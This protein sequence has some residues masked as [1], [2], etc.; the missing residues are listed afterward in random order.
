M[1]STTLQRL[2]LFLALFVGLLAP[3]VALPQTPDP[4]SVQPAQ[5]RRVYLPLVQRAPLGNSIRFAVIGDYG[6]DNQPEADVAKL[7]KS[8]NPYFIVT[9]GDNNYP[10]GAAATI[11][12]NVGK[13]YYQ[14]ISPYS[15]QYGSNSG[16]N[17]F[18][19]VMGNHD[20][21][22][23]NGKPYLNYFTLPNNERYYE[24]ALGP[25]RVFGLDSDEREP[26]GVTATSKQ[27]R[28]LQRRLAASRTCW[29]VVVS[30]HSPF[31]SGLHQG[32]TP[33]M[34]WPFRT[35]GADL[36]LSGHDHLY[37]RLSIGGLTFIVNGLGG[38]S[39]HPF[40]T[41]LAGSQ[42]RYSA[43]YG[44]LLVDA[45]KTRLLMRFYSRTGRLIDTYTLPKTCA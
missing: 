18:F 33:Y 12:Q 4:A 9:V 28:W 29:D 8:W 44:A 40:G 24:V 15:G 43:D 41:P 16:D 27:G 3:N 1:F 26:D 6:A 13:Y 39:L 21:D 14:F 45:D 19:P 38:D 11:D 42:V 10:D 7:V 30:H 37:E 36:V 32:S 2:V 17:R 5:S 34:Q 31:S 22:S 35:W 25:V 20:W 23:S